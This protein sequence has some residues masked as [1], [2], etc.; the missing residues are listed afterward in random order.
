MNLS[1]A[2][3]NGASGV[4]EG[5]RGIIRTAMQTDVRHLANQRRVIRFKILTRHNLSISCYTTCITIRHCDCDLHG[6][7][8]FK[9]LIVIVFQIHFT[10]HNIQI[11][12]L[13]IG[14]SMQK[15]T[16]QNGAYFFLSELINAN[17]KL[18]SRTRSKCAR[19]SSQNR[20]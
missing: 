7:S 18:Q 2:W 17:A 15:R 19:E 4:V 1:A 16:Q 11:W 10:F 5:R 9:R 8:D 3:L 12:W 20:I 6:Y 14:P 13:K